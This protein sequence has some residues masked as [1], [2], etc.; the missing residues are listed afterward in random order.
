MTKQD[1][2][3]IISNPEMIDYALLRKEESLQLFPEVLDE[4]LTEADEDFEALLKMPDSDVNYDTFMDPFF[5]GDE[6]LS[7]LFKAVDSFNSTDSND[8]TRKI[9]ADF[10]PKLVDFQ[11]KVSLN[12]DLYA[13]LKLIETQELS[14]DE[15]RSLSL[16]IRDM[17][18]AGVH[19]PEEKREQLK[20]IKRELSE[21]SEKFSNNVTDSK[22]EFFYEIEDDT[23][24]KDVHLEDLEAAREEAK[25]RDSKA[26][27]VFTLSPPSYLAIMRYCEDEKIREIFHKAN[28]TVATQGPKDNRGIALRILKLRE[29]KA[30]LLGF[31]NFAEYILQE[32]MAPSPEKVIEILKQVK[33]IA[34]K[35]AQKN[36]DGLKQY[37][38]KPDFKEW[39]ISFYAEKL[40]MEKYKVDEKML[41]PYFALDNVLKGLFRL[42]KTLFDLDM[43]L[44]DMNEYAPGSK[45]YKVF[46]KGEHISY[47]FLDVYT[48]PAKRPG[49]WANDLR[50][51]YIKSNGEKRLPIVINECNFPT[52]NGDKPS[53]LTHRDVETIF[54]EFGHAIHVMLSSQNLANLNGFNTEWDFVEAPSQILENWCWEH[55]VLSLFAKHY[56]TSE[57]IPQETI[58]K[59]K[60]SKNFMSGLFLMR[61]NEFGFLDFLLHTE[62]VPDNVE[63]LDKKCEAI[64]NEYGALKK[65]EGYSMYTSFSHIF[66]GGYSA[67]YYSYVWAEI[68]EADMYEKAKEMGI[69]SPEFGEKYVNEILAPGTKKPA[70]ELFTNFIG[71]EPDIKALFK[72]HGISL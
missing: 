31:N 57:V 3:Q 25:K 13:K 2:L 67:G 28:N 41:R 1:L 5:T 56:E 8:Q 71:G 24:L 70:M 61:Q 17:E 9:I 30:K 35:E 37:S 43:K 48:R 32:R 6:V 4:L 58:D 51:G 53:L 59:L 38:G 40:K 55:E 14:E 54:H 50:S 60:D 18:V 42:V 12:S 20:G 34:G 68:M 29:E 65:F 21:L 11:N 52:P 33:A 66:A 39:D 27:F 22:A 10:Q 36:V 44:I 62:P 7:N 26:E 23:S 46:H 16:V 15:R 47:Y 19:L 64:C 63:A 72:K 69:L 45:A 49:A